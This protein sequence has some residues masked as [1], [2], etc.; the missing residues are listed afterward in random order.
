MATD[1]GVK[2][3]LPGFNVETAADA[4]LY[5]N[6][7]WPLLKID[8]SISGTLTIA[9]NAS[10]DVITHNL[11][12]PP[13]VMIWSH[14]N[15]FWPYYISSINSQTIVL[16]GT[17]ASLNIGD[18]VRYYVFRNPLNTNFQAPNIALASVQQ[19]TNHQD[20]GIKFAKQ[21]KNTSST[22]L[23]DYTIH[24]GTKSLQVHQVLTGPFA[25]YPVQGGGTGWGFRYVTDLPYRPVQFAFY[26]TDNINFTPVFAAAQVPPKVLYETITGANIISNGVSSGGYGVFV[27]LLDPYQSNNQINVTL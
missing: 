27:V 25:S 9:G 3:S 10:L 20:F 5:F 15:G 22:D 2:V 6:S 26:S 8:D 7:S 23:R 11:N 18:N 16:G 19:G 4:D 12:Y 1:F 14:N 17:T 21:N 24:S 13:F